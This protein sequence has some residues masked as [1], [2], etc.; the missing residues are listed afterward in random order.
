MQIQNRAAREARAIRRLCCQ[1]AVEVLHVERRY[2]PACTRCFEKLGESPL[3]R[4]LWKPFHKAPGRAVFHRPL[5]ALA[6][7]SVRATVAADAPSARQP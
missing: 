7:R 3:T 4:P 2:L 1:P 6:N 5:G